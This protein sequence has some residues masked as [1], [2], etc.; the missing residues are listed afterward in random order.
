MD[1]IKGNL[2]NFAEEGL[3]DVIIHGC[4][5]FCT[6]GAGIADE[7]R[8]RH[9]S[10]YTADCKTVKGDKS[11][12]GTHSST[13][14][15]LNNHEFTIINAY[16]QFGYGHDKRYAD[17]CAIKDVMTKISK[18]FDGRKIGYPMIGAGK[19]G[20]DWGI[21]SKLIDDAFSQKNH[22]LVIRTP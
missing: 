7:I 17:Y 19:A 11:K 16:T 8:S 4:N 9:P 20:G 18:D 15:T 12:L 21:I 1:S 5:C 13:V 22:K 14:V 6:M 2:I 10:A 3:F